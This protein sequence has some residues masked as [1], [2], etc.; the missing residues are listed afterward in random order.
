RG[1]VIAGTVR[2]PDG[3]PAENMAVFVSG[4]QMVAGHL[5]L[6]LTGGRST[7]DDRGRYRV[8]GLPAGDYVVQVR[9]S[10]FLAG[11]PAGTTDAPQ[12]TASEVSWAQEVAR[13]RA[14]RTTSTA[15]GPA[16]GRTMAY[17]PVVFP[18][19][20]DPSR[21]SIVSIAAGEERDGVDFP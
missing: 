13:L 17:A 8:Y 3:R 6:R 4:V 12:T 20:A 7:T 16:H 14:G 1:A 19:S 10:G 11:V 5:R 18:G 9:P 15:A 2:L 21:A